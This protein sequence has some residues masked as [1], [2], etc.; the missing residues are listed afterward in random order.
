[1]KESFR[2]GTKE[3]F[4]RL[5]A[6][7]GEPWRISLRASIQYGYS[8]G[9]QILR[10]FSDNYDS[11]LDIGCSQGQFTL[12]LQSIASRITAIDIAETAI[13]RARERYGNK[14]KIKFELGSLPPLKYGDSQFDLVV[15]LEVLYYLE[16]EEQRRALKEVKRVLKN[17]GHFLI[18]VVVDKPPYFSYN[19]IRELVSAEFIIL[20]EQVIYHKLHYLIEAKTCTLLDIMD[21]VQRSKF[22]SSSDIRGKLSRFSLDVARWPL[23]RILGSMALLK[24]CN[25]LTRATMGDKGVTRVI[26]LAKRD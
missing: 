20:K 12:M 14:G 26:I 9:L 16:K 17:D 8:L 19:Q 4:D 2:F 22:F 6:S 25:R 24:T 3:Y 13:Q 7:S 1:M 23:E 5:Y 15:A 21:Y 18:S 10:Q 11:V